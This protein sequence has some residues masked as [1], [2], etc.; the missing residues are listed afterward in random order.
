MFKKHQLRGS[1]SIHIEN[2]PGKVDY[3]VNSKDIINKIDELKEALFNS[4]L[5]VDKYNLSVHTPKDPEK[6]YKL[7]KY[8]QDRDKYYETPDDYRFHKSIEKYNEMKKTKPDYELNPQLYIKRTINN[9]KISKEL[10]DSVNNSIKKYNN[11]ETLTEEDYKNL[12]EYLENQNIKNNKL[13]TIKKRRE[14]IKKIIDER[15]PKK[16]EPKKQETKQ[17]E[18]PIKRGRPKGSKNKTKKLITKKE[19][20]DEEKGY[21]LFM[22]RPA[23]QPV[24]NPRNK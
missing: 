17:E 23:V 3:T 9:N 22:W 11:K 13:P 4:R 6:G 1:G 15:L 20:Y 18:T 12:A 5:K 2:T 7:P 8:M 24:V 14:D 10:K 16:E 19:D 21:G